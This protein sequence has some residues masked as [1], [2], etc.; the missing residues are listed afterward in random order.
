MV[1]I[2]KSILLCGASTSYDRRMETSSTFGS[3]EWRDILW[4]W[5]RRGG[6]SRAYLLA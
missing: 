3:Q 5:D 1:W 2:L 6:Q 4:D